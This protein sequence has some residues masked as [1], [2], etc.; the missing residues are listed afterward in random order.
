MPDNVRVQGAFLS[1]TL[2]ALMAFKGF[3]FCVN[4]RVLAEVIFTGKT[5]S[6]LIAY[7]GL[8]VIVN[9]HVLV[10]VVFT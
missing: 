1:E 10:K 6:A 3:L 4:P 7:I 9:P 8:V 5:L 2:S